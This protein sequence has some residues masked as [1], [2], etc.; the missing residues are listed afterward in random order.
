MKK[1]ILFVLTFVLA[2]VVSAN[3]WWDAEVKQTESRKYMV[4]RHVCL[5]GSLYIGFP[6]KDKS[7]GQYAAMLIPAYKNDGLVKACSCSKSDKKPPL[8][9]FVIKR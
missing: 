9:S 7:I 2:T 6:G 8:A 4:L 5:D 3:C 1:F